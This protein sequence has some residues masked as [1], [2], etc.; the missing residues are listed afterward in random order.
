MNLPNAIFW[1]DQLRLVFSDV[2]ETV[3]DLY[4]PAEA[5]MLD[6]I[7]RLLDHGI[8]LVLITGQSV[9]SVEQRIVMRLTPSARK[10]IAVGGCGGAELWGYSATGDRNLVAFDSAI[11]AL[12][13]EQ[14]LA[15]REAVQ[16]LIAE[17]QLVPLPVMPITEFK[18]QHGN[19]PCHVL[20]DDRGPQITFE[21]PN[22]YQLSD[23]E[24]AEISRRLATNV[25]ET[26][27]RVPFSRRAGELLKARSVPVTPR[28]GGVFAVDLAI[29]GVSKTRAVQAALRPDVL[30]ALG[31]GGAVPDAGEMEIWGDRFSQQ[32][33]TD[34]LMCTALDPSV[35]AISFRE[36]D[37]TEFPRGYNIQLWGGKQR[38]HAGLLE[39]LDHACQSAKA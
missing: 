18:L 32:A 19:N 35:R 13:E 2:D 5:G 6:A 12:N 37:P 16:Q 23:V 28:M 33:G 30:D 31:L 29:E 27:L 26:D 4:R 3:A 1:N 14:M 11:S 7:T 36:E 9:D 22:A 38:L 24:R 34:W 25:E 15:W 20:L 10:Q 21:F 17:F 8:R 39:F